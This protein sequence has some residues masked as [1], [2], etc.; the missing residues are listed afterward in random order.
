M[1]IS[2]DIGGFVGS[3][4]GVIGA[5]GVTVYTINKQ[6]KMDQPKALKSAF[7]CVSAIKQIIEETIFK[8]EYEADLPSKVIYLIVQCRGKLEEKLPDAIE[9][10]DKIVKLI[11]SV[12]VDLFE[13]YRKFAKVEKQPEKLAELINELRLVL[14]R[15][16]EICESMMDGIRKGRLN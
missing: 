2:F 15:N 7:L 9:I 10:D 6:R 16:S 13:T 5:F 12:G 4:L 3:I 14:T 1:D 11:D 8:L